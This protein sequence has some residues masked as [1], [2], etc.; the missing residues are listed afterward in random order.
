MNQYVLDEGDES[1]EFSVRLIAQHVLRE[2]SRM[3]GSPGQVAIGAASQARLEQADKLRGAGSAHWWKSREAGLLGLGILAED[4]EDED[5]QA[6]LPAGMC[7]PCVQHSSRTL[8]ILRLGRLPR[9]FGG[10]PAAVGSAAAREG[11]QRTSGR[12]TSLPVQPVLSGRGSGLPSRLRRSGRSGTASRP[13]GHVRR[14]F[15][16]GGS[17]SERGLSDGQA[18]SVPSSEQACAMPQESR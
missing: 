5:Y 18:R 12:V 16:R 9:R 3:F 8:L 11:T 10:C 17:R 6:N 15:G 14:S 7:M 1:F 4:L 13:V 2:I